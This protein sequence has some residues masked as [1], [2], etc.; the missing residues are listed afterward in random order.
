[1]VT[2]RAHRTE[3][4]TEEDETRWQMDYRQGRGYDEGPRCAF[5]ELNGVFRLAG[6]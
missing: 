3:H 4:V 1:M 5:F 6:K 2:S